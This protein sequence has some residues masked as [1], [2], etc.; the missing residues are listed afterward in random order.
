MDRLT[1]AVVVT[2]NGAAPAVASEWF[3][4][5]IGGAF[6]SNGG[7]NNSISAVWAS[8]T[9]AFA[10]G[11]ALGMVGFTVPASAVTSQT[12]SATIV[13]VSAALGN[14]IVGLGCPF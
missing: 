12:Y 13:G 10:G 6:L 3:S 14:N 11:G 1:F 5:S 9:L 2:P 7:T 4:P 8:P